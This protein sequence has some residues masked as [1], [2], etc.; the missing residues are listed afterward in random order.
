MSDAQFFANTVANIV[1]RHSLI[2]RDHPKTF[3]R[4]VMKTDNLYDNN[5]F[6]SWDDL[7]NEFLSTVRNTSNPCYSLWRGMFYRVVN[8]H[9]YYDNRIRVCANWSIFANFAEYLL[10]NLGKKP[11]A[12]YHIDRIDNNGNYEPGNIRW[13]SQYLQHR[14]RRDTVLNME[15]SI[16]AAHLYKYYKLTYKKLS[17][18]LI[19]ENLVCRQSKDLPAL[20]RHAFTVYFETV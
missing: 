19:S 16:I 14:N 7:P 3:K 2:L 12:F 17:R 11:K 9:R 20:S 18:I 10:E 6:V 15:Q 4:S 5:W 1:S 13:A 8:N